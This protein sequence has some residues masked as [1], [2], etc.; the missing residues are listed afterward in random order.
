MNETT[1]YVAY[2]NRGSSP[3]ALR[4][5]SNRSHFNVF[6]FRELLASSGGHAYINWYRPARAGA[7]P[8][9]TGTHDQTK[10]PCVNAV[11]RALTRC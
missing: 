1:R 3:L 9:S 10:D 5:G 11:R 8:V 7:V 6:W 2:R 4:S